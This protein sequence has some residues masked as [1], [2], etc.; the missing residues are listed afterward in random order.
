[1]ISSSVIGIVA[2]NIVSVLSIACMGCGFSVVD[3]YF[4][5]KVRF[6]FTRIVIYF[7]GIILLS[8]VTGFIG[9]LN[10]YLVFMFI[11]M[12]DASRDFRK[13]EPVKFI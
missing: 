1:M 8:V 11:G 5:K 13:I 3:F 9:F 12:I 6:S 2:G 4:K 7:F 10:P